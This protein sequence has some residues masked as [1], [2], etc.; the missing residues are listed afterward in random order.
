MDLFEPG[1]G[2]Q[3]HD[4]N[5]GVPPSGLFWTVQL[6]DSEFRMSEN[7]RHAVLDA[8]DVPVLDSFVIFGPNSIPAAL[9]FHLRWDATGPAAQLGEGDSV[10]P[11]DPA[12]FLAR[13]APARAS[14]WIRATE[15]GFGFRSNP[16]LSSALGYAELGRERNGV[17]I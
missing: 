12:A 8:R 15:V 11:T 9:S 1:S 10:D 5:G 16:G 4:L 13:F 17:F 7:R 2:S 14:G 6:R 3:V